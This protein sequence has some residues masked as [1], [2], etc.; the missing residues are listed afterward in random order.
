MSGRFVSDAANERPPL[1]GR[2]PH[3]MNRALL[4]ELEK[5]DV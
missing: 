1:T 5:I 3:L 2:H 4:I